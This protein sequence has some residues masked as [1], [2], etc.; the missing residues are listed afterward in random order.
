MFVDGK[1]L[2]ETYESEIEEI[3]SDMRED[4]TQ[5]SEEYASKMDRF[6][7]PVTMRRSY[8]PYCLDYDY[9]NYE[10]VYGDDYYY[11]YDYVYECLEWSE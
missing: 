9:S 2:S 5:M 6:R 1:S 11:G 3:L 7:A 8:E 10:V 4:G